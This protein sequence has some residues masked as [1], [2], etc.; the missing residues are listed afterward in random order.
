MN[1]LK[2]KRSVQPES[3]LSYL[4]HDF[5]LIYREETVEA[6]YE[7]FRRVGL[8]HKIIYLYVVDKNKKL[9]GVL[10][11]RRLLISPLNAVVNELYVP[12][13]VSLSSEINVSEAREAFVRNKF[14][15]FPVVDKDQ[16]ILGILDIESFAGDLGDITARSKFDE[17]YEIF[18]MN[19]NEAIDR[20]QWKRTYIRMPWLLVTMTCGIF[21]ALITG[22]FETTLSSSLFVTFFVTLILGINESMAMQSAT[23]AVHQLHTGKRDKKNFLQSLR[24]EIIS[25]V[26]IGGAMGLLSAIVVFQWKEASAMAPVLALSLTVTTVLS[27]LWGI[28]VPSLLHALK[29]DPKVA[30]GPLVL[31]LTDLSTLTLYFS[32]AKLLLK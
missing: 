9:L 26:I 12:N 11:I 27:C 21:A 30:I 16:H 17:V 5:P 31:G 8:K 32:I 14:L 3:V 13:C 23:L 1:P 24:R 15:A 19:L 2:L 4:N 20:S 10:P 29:K 6:V 25:A 7:K 28:S 18:G 22:F